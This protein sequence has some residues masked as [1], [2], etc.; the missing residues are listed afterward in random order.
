MIPIGTQLHA[1]QPAEGARVRSLLPVTHQANCSGRY[2]KNIF[3]DDRIYLKVS[4][5]EGNCERFHLHGAECSSNGLPPIIVAID[6]NRQSLKDLSFFCA[7]LP[8]NSARHSFQNQ[9]RPP[10]SHHSS[11]RQRQH[12]S[13]RWHSPC[14]PDGRWSGPSRRIVLRGQT[15]GPSV[16][17]RIHWYSRTKSACSIQ[18]ESFFAG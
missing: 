12:N 8:P 7:P 11:A 15:S 4:R 2:K 5:W 14:N 18:N 10:L 13:S 6:G 1:E 3:D 9:Y 17:A 16:E